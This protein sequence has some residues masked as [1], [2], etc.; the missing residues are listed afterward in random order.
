[1]GKSFTYADAVTLLGA[2]QSRIVTA[3][4]KIAG[5]TLLGGVAYGIDELLSWFDAKVDFVRYSH[6]LL[7]KAREK[8]RGLSRYDQTQRPSRRAISRTPWP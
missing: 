4:E 5:V 2:K 8:R 3:L 6:E 7:I 1:M